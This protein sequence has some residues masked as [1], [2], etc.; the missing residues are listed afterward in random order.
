MLK[1]I[2]RIPQWFYDGMLSV[3]V[4]VKVIGIGLLPILIL[5]FTLSYWI[6][7]GLSDWLSYILSDVRVQ[8]AMEAGQ[9]SVNLVTF[10]AGIISI[11]FSLILSYILSRPILLLREMAQQVAEGNLSARAPIW[12]KDE[13]GELPLIR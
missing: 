3:P 13:I 7:T 6:T 11:Y 5:G 8:A 4:R 12:A 1:K 9:R 2:K 10:L